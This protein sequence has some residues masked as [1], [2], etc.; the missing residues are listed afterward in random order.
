MYKLHHMQAIPAT[1]EEVWEFLSN[2]RQ[3]EHITSGKMAFE[4]TKELPGTMYEGMIIELR[5]APILGIPMHWVSEITHIEE[6]VRFIDEQRF[7]PFRFWHHEHRLTEKDGG[8]IMEDIVHYV[9]PFAFIGRIVH[10]LFV[11]KMIEEIFSERRKQA[12]AFFQ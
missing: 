2:P 6:R 1:R 8:I 7:G 3:L 9:M 10:R 11:R 4:A 5:I 12:E